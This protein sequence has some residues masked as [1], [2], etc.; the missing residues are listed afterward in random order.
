MS[1]AKEKAKQ[2]Q[3]TPA[4]D[5]ASEGSRTRSDASSVAGRSH[6]TAAAQ[7]M[8][9]M[10]MDPAF[11]SA[12]DDALMHAAIKEGEKPSTG[13]EDM[14]CATSCMSVRGLRERTMEGE[15]RPRKDAA[16]ALDSVPG[17]DDSGRTLTSNVALDG[18]SAAKRTSIGPETEARHCVSP[19]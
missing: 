13:D 17:S 11:S 3:P 7:T 9:I 5:S 8:L 4:R 16:S 1:A 2:P 15:R 6:E 14:D 10:G 12:S 18:C 19:F